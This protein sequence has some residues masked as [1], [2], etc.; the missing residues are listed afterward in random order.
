MCQL[1]TTHRWCSEAHGSLVEPIELKTV[2][3]GELAEWG[4][5][6]H[7][8]WF[9]GPLMADRISFLHHPFLSG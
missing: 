4:E 8:R 1:P 2:H 6:I 9:G 7:P 5:G 3:V